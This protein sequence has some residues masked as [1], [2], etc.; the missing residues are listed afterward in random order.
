VSSDR[1]ADN[2]RLIAGPAG[3]CAARGGEHVSL[4]SGLWDDPACCGIMLV[5]LAHHV[6]NAD[7]QGAGMDHLEALA[8]IR[9]VFDAEWESS[10][11]E[12]HGG[13]LDEAADA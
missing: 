12:V 10:T 9:E 11:D 2:C 13:L 8:R 7:E 5:D 1:R 3:S 4:A 6:A